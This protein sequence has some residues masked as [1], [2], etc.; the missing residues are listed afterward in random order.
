MALTFYLWTLF[1]IASSGMLL[2]VAIMCAFYSF[3][4]FHGEF[5]LLL[6][7]ISLTA[8]NVAVHIIYPIEIFVFSIMILV[9]FVGSFQVFFGPLHPLSKLALK[10][11]G[12]GDL[13]G[14]IVALLGVVLMLELTK[15]AVYSLL[16]RPEML[17]R[18]FAGESEPLLGIGAMSSMVG[19]S[20][21]LSGIV[22]FILSRNAGEESDGR[23]END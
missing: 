16:V 21:V 12:I 17:H 4:L 11:E 18:F 6:E 2:F 5:Y 22:F 14:K 13:C 8:G 1:F 10:V 3:A 7:S 19:A 9:L 20:L 15:T 23:N